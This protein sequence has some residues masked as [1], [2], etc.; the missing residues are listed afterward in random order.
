MKMTLYK[1]NPKNILVLIRINVDHLILSFQARVVSTGELAAVKIVKIEPGKF[2]MAIL[3][4]FLL[5]TLRN[6]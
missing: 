6:L 1:D 2:L 3:F 5:K 4:T